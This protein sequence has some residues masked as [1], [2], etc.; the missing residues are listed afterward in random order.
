MAQDHRSCLTRR[1]FLRASAWGALGSASSGQPVLAATSRTARARS[2][3]LIY[4]GGGIS[5]HDTFDPKPNAPLEV[6]GELKT[7]QTSLAG[8]R[9]GELL[10]RLAARVT[11]CA[12]IRSVQHTQTDHGVSAYFMLRGFVQPDPT[13][14]RPENQ[15]RAHPTIGSHVA[16]LL[17]S[18]NGMPPY[19]CVPGL[20]YLASV[21]YY[22]AGWMGRAYDPFLLKSDPNAPN[23][24]VTRLPLQLE[25]TSERLQQRIALARAVEESWRRLDSAASARGM[26]VQYETAYRVLSSET[27]RRAL[28]L[29]RE[30]ARLRDAYGRM[31]M[32][33]S[34]LLARRLV[35]AGVPFVT[36]DDFDWDHHAQIFPAL[37][38]QL[39]DLDQAL[40][41]LLDDLRD[42]GL[43]QTTLV[44]LLTDFGRTP[45]INKSSGRDHWPAVGSVLL[46]GAGIPGGQ[47]VGSSDKVGAAVRDQPVSPKDLAATLYHFL[48]I[49]PFQEYRATDGRPLQVLDQGQVLRQL[50]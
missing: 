49:N 2:V 4:A 28:D 31:R 9:F 47:V 11:S 36:V 35:E 1:T 41:M 25:V 40:T 24:K 39:P 44:A 12:L 8:V 22:T 20:S 19:I 15:L 42:R 10:P 45:V 43:L 46:A 18:T 17:G 26:S 13:F 6:R 32:G 38:R 7:I 27:A 34:C 3:V 5:H 23:F 16:R 21:N 29:D 14:D 30:P 33:Q 37:R 50:R 48:G